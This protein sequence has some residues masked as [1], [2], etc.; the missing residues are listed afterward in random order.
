M[1]GKGLIH[2]NTIDFDSETLETVSICKAIHE[3][4]GLSLGEI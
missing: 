3:V 1:W 4:F 2:Q